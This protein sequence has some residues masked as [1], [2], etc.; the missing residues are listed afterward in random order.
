MLRLL[1]NIIFA[2]G[3]LVGAV[4]YRLGIVARIPEKYRRFPLDQ[5]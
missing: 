1:G 4:K 3:W 2:I 5:R